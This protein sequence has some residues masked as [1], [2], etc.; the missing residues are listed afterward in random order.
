M[1]R[2]L[3]FILLNFVLGIANAQDESIVM[4]F[5][6]FMAKVK[7]H[8][9]MA[10]QSQILIESGD[11]N[12][13]MARGSFDPKLQGN[14]AQKYFKDD[15]YYSIINGGLKIPTWYGISFQT[16]VDMNQGSQL[17]PER[18]VPDDGLW[19]AGVTVALGRGMIIDQRRAELKKAKIF[20]ESSVQAQRLMMND[21]LLQS[22]MAY[23]DWFKAYN[24]MQ[25][26]SAF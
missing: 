8:H 7:Q 16:G 5:E 18:Y 3:L 1:K 19:Y 10:R 17:N 23:W 13:M 24:K 26:A 15:Q 4:E 11:A 20:V 9:P 21:L 14:V 22:S 25:K 6:Q 2:T 12:L